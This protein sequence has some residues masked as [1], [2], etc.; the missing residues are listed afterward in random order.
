MY[1]AANRRASAAPSPSPTPTT[2]HAGFEDWGIVS[3]MTCHLH[4]FVID[5]VRGFLILMTLVI[6][7][8]KRR[9]PPL[10]IRN[11]T[12]AVIGAGDYIGAAI[13]KKFAAEGFHGFRRTTQRRQACAA[14]RR[15]SK[16]HGG[17]IVARSLDARKEDEITRFLTDADGHAPLEVCIFNVG[18]NVNFPLL[19][20]TE[21]V[22]RKVWE[23]ACYCGLPCCARGGAPDAAARA[24]MPFLHRRDRESARGRGLCGI[25]QPRSSACAR[26][27]RA[28]RASWDRRISM[29]RI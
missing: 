19:D 12:A 9:R 24:R 1:P 13:A 10:Q 4:R 21:R 7:S 20:T 26:W 27:R 29:S 25:R 16:P 15:T 18:A 22:F 6:N 14:G 23:M 11:A 5:R 17:R 3:P 2:M 28:P 8:V